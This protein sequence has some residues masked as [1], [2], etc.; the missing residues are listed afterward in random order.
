MST[1]RPPSFHKAAI[2]AVRNAIPISTNGLVLLTTSYSAGPFNGGLVVRL[3]IYL[4]DELLTGMGAYLHI[5]TWELIP[6]PQCR[7]Q[8]VRK[9]AIPR[10]RMSVDLNDK[11]FIGHGVTDTGGFHSA[12]L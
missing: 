7:F 1:K 12:P 3:W 8:R 11:E 5:V 2:T 4:C 10:F 9:A 6:E